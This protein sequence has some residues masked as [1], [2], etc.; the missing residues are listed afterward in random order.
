MLRRPIRLAIVWIYGD[1]PSAPMVLAEILNKQQAICEYFHILGSAYADPSR[2]GSELA[3]QFK[4]FKNLEYRQVI[5]EFVLTKPSLRWLNN[6]EI[7]SGVITALDAKQPS[8][9]F[10]L[11]SRKFLRE[12]LVSSVLRKH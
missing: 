1:A 5:L 9:I 11:S 12:I 7:S 8:S 10:L 4:A 6:D 3:E 2:Q